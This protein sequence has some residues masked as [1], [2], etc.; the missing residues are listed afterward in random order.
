MKF[1][2]PRELT[3]EKLSE[4]EQ[5]KPVSIVAKQHSDSCFVNFADGQ[6]LVLNTDIIAGE[7][8]S[9]SKTFSADEIR[10]FI[11]MQRIITAK[12]EA[13][14]YASMRKRSE[15]QIRGKLKEKGFLPEETAAAIDFLKKFGMIDDE[16]FARAFATEKVTK[17][18]LGGARLKQELRRAGV[19]DEISASVIEEIAPAETEEILDVMRKLT[20]KKL[21]MIAKKEPEKQKNSLILFL[22]GKGYKYE[23]IKQ[24]IDE[25]DFSADQKSN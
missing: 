11:L 15:F 23:Y 13:Y 18:Q 25:T 1:Q 12:K 6:F 4:N 2:N 8:I 17:K 20:E 14:R 7:R 9:K 10:K 24:I 21:R 16:E 3:L 5:Y 19:S 22:T